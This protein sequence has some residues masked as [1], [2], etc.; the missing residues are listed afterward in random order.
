MNHLF[1]E[2]AAA[3]YLVNNIYQTD[4]G[5][6]RVN[7]RKPVSGGDLFTAF[8]SAQSLDDALYEALDAI[9]EAEF[10]AERAISSSIDRSAPM[11]LAQALGLRSA[12]PIPIRPLRGRANEQV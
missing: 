11:S 7:L 5:L 9:A 6:W 3:G 4:E 1:A 2:I 8:A 10:A 12:K